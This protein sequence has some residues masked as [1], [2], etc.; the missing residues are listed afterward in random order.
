MNRGRRAA[1]RGGEMSHIDW[2]WW[3]RVAGVALA[4]LAAGFFMGM[5]LGS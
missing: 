4:A 1:Q 3:G 2:R 5:W